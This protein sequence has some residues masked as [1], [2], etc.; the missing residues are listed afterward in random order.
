MA[1]D[2]LESAGWH[3]HSIRSSETFAQLRVADAAEVVI[4]DFVADPVPLVEQP[5][6]ITEGGRTIQIDT[7][8]EIFVNKLCALI[9]RQEWRDL[10]DVRSLIASGE[11]L[12]LGLLHAPIKDGGFSPLTLV[13]ILK[14][15]PIETLGAKAQKS[16]EECAAMRRFV[17]DL[18]V[19]VAKLSAD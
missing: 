11:D 5:T 9:G 19:A 6:A 10:D 12:R 17:E 16:A 15:Y 3:V 4:V 13:W 8:H 2:R 14:S 1:R 7:R 18:I